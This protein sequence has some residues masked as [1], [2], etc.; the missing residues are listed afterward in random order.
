MVNGVKLKLVLDSS[1]EKIQRS[2]LDFFFLNIQNSKCGF[3]LGKI[4]NMVMKPVSYIWD[5]IQIARLDEIY[6]FLEKKLLT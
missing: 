4:I 3:C 5:S 6:V 1:E 2:K